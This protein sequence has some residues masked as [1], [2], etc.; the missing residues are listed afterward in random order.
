[1]ELFG[2]AKL[3]GK[4]RSIAFRADIDALVMNEKNFH[5][6]Y[7]STNECAH[8]CGHDGHT[9]SLLGIKYNYF[10]NLIRSCIIILRK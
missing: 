9:V 2:K 6:S 10:L 4:P 5:L 8:M 7:R 3:E 1:V